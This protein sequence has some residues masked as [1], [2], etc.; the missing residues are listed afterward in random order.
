MPSS[1]QLSA[2]MVIKKTDLTNQIASKTNH[3]MV[4]SDG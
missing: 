4:N 1:L 3:L 2:V